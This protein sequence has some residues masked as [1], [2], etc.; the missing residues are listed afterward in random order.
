MTL[1]IPD[2]GVLAK[3]EDAGI[4]SPKPAVSHAIVA[5]YGA[6]KH[7]TNFEV[8]TGW[9]SLPVAFN[10]GAS[11]EQD[12]T[13]RIKLH[14]PQ[15]YKVVD[16]AAS[17]QSRPPMVP[18]IE[19]TDHG[20]LDPVT[21]TTNAT[22]KQQPPVLHEMS[23]VASCPL[24]T[25]SGDPATFKTQIRAK[26][27]V[28]REKLYF[29]AADATDVGLDSAAKVQYRG[30]AP[31]DGNTKKIPVNI[32]SQ[33]TFVAST[34]PGYLEGAYVGLSNDPNTVNAMSDKFKNQLTYSTTRYGNDAYKGKV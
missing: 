14:H 31:N 30:K 23:F 34:G 28:A 11:A 12:H 29:D 15:Y 16:Y 7:D 33:Y 2:Y 26:Y 4:Y 1:E 19:N 9:I 20:T 18:D 5:P 6:L 24:S 22:T 17:R 25:T 3:Y 21:T 32:L 10:N 27:S 8:N 13:V